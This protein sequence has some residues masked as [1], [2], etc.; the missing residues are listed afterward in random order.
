[1][2]LSVRDLVST[3]LV[4]GIGV[5]YTMFLTGSDLPLVD[6]TRT[7]ALAGLAL[8]ALAFLVGHHYGV[9]HD[10]AGTVEAAAALLALVAGTVAAVVTVGSSTADAVLA[11]FIALVGV[12]WLVQVLRHAGV[13]HG[14]HDTRVSA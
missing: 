11:V 12:T 5:V 3:V 8:G 2:K 9:T 1:M 13:L 6:D 10:S 14:R 7:M 4:L